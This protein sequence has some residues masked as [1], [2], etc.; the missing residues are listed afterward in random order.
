VSSR[1]D[2]GA[3]PWIENARDVG[4]LAFARRIESRLDRSGTADPAIALES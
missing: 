1:G 4:V 3:S 2:Y